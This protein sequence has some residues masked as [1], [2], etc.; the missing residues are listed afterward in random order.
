MFIGETKKV[1]LTFST[2]IVTDLDDASVQELTMNVFVGKRVLLKFK[3]GNATGFDGVITVDPALKN[4][5]SALITSA[6]SNRL[7]PGELRAQVWLTK[8]NGGES[9]KR[10]FEIVVENGLV[11]R[12]VL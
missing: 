5:A 6:L 4:R 1:V 9:E 12:P 8:L 10:A 2:A 11:K 7:I 3:K